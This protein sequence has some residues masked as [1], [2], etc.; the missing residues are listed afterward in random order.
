MHMWKMYIFFYQFKYVGLVVSLE[1]NISC[2]QPLC[3][4]WQY[5][6]LWTFLSIKS[7]SYERFCA[8]YVQQFTKNFFNS[9]HINN[10]NSLHKKIIRKRSEGKSKMRKDFLIYDIYKERSP[11]IKGNALHEETRHLWLCTRALTGSLF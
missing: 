8:C 5:T 11:N 3:H 10:S 4:N 9:V 1:I 6:V 7:Y 2:S